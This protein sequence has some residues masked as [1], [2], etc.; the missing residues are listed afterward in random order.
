MSH[1]T[2]E[3]VQKMVTPFAYGT[4]TLFGGPFQRPSARSGIFLGDLGVS[5][6]TPHNPQEA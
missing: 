1:G 6:V 3:R 5:P 4:L 2:R